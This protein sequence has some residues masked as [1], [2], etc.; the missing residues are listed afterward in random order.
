MNLK[1]G[2]E[3]A[4]TLGAVRRLSRR[5][6][7]HAKLTFIPTGST[8]GYPCADMHETCM[9]VIDAYGPDRCVWGSDFPCEL[10]TPKV[11]YAEHLRIFR[12]DLPLSTEQREQILGK[13]ARGLWFR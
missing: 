4:P 8:T 11:S 12:E 2:P 3:L 1:A 6:N 10:W 13:T 7:L 5:K 9:Q